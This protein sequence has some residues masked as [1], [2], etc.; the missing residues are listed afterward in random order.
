[1]WT[2]G[3]LAVE[4]TE[5]VPVNGIVPILLILKPL[6]L[7]GAQA[8]SHFSYALLGVTGSSSCS[9]PCRS[10]LLPPVGVTRII[11]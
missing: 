9:C 5:S 8:P 4:F 10:L 1:M 2:A 3:A 6:A 11:A 7:V